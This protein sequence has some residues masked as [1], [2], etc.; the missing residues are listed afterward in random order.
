MSFQIGL[1]AT[2]RTNIDLQDRTFAL[3]MGVSQ[4]DI[5]DPPSLIELGVQKLRTRKTIEYCHI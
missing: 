5:E 1:K 2:D 4:S 3:K